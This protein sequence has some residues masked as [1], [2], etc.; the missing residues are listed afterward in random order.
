MIRML[1][2]RPATYR[3]TAAIR[4][5]LHERSLTRTKS[6]LSLRKTHS[7]VGIS[8]TITA[9][10][11]PTQESVH[12]P[13]LSCNRAVG[14]ASTQPGGL[15]RRRAPHFEIRTDD[16]NGLLVTKSAPS[17]GASTAV[18]VRRVTQTPRPDRPLQVCDEAV[19][20]PN[21]IEDRPQDVAIRSSSSI[22]DDESPTL[23]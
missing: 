12:R 18:R 1:V 9:R 17:Q 10:S 14:V 4:T 3:L 21:R 20:R 16:N 19:Q 23:S 11:D 6:A 22:L 15:L 5:T 7:Q 2:R 13:R 8:I